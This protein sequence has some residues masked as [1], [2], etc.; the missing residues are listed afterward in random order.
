MFIL[1]APD[2]HPQP[3]TIAHDPVMLMAYQ[4]MMDKAGIGRSMDEMIKAG[5]KIQKV[6][7]TITDKP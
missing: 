3:S 5:F 6:F 2:G 1:V 7:V 4:K